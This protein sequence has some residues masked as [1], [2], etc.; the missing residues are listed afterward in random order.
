M[1]ATTMPNARNVFAASWMGA[2][3]AVG[4]EIDPALVALARANLARSRLRNRRVEF[5]ESGAEAYEQDQSTVIFMFNPF[6][7]GTMAAVTAGIAACGGQQKDVHAFGRIFRE[8]ASRAQ[9]LVVRVREHGHQL[10]SEHVIVSR[11]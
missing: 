9:R 2:R 10:P 5:V 7:A 4:V 11:F 1:A 6:G 8:R 3:R